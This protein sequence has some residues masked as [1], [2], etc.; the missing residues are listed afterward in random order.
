MHGFGGLA[1]WQWLFL[2]EGLPAVVL[3]F[4]VLRRL[5]ERPEDARWLSEAERRTLARLSRERSPWRNRRGRPLRGAA[6]RPDV[7]A[8]P[9][10][11]HD[12]G[13]DCT[14]S[15]SSCLRC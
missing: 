10:V 2:L 8:R 5:A 11:F 3:G 14:A 6:Q 13:D 9:R 15:D 4:V 1:G 7:A 12:P